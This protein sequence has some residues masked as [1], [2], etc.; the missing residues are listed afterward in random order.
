MKRKILII[1]FLVLI[2]I[3]FVG[4]TANA[5]SGDDD[6]QEINKTVDNILD[7]IDFEDFEKYLSEIPS[8]LFPDNGNIKD[9][10]KLLMSGEGIGDFSSVFSY[11][12]NLLGV[13]VKDKL[14]IF[15]SLII[16]L[17]AGGIVDAMKP[18]GNS[19]V[20]EIVHF[21]IYSSAICIV[22]AIV[23]SLVLSAKQTIDKTSGLIEGVMPIVLALMA[24][25]GQQTSVALYNPASVFTTGLTTVF[26]E[27]VIF[28]IIVS[29]LVVNVVSNIN[30]SLK[31]T[32]L[33]G[34]LAGFIK[35]TFGL[36]AVI[37]SVF[38]TARGIVSGA[39]DGISVKA[40]KYAVNS[41]V[42][43]VGGILKDGVDIII[44]SAILIKNA[45]GIYS[46]IA[47]AGIVIVPIIELIAVSF[48]LKLISAVAEPIGDARAISFIDKV[49]STVNYL[50]ASIL[51]VAFMGIVMMILIL[52]SSQAI[53]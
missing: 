49:S 20:G 23:Y 9:S 6:K 13:T 8:T 25:T 27:N 10:L 22:G 39:F 7:N 48:A 15:I 1:L 50:I 28:P 51:I 53:L 24:A 32:N 43:I 34:F 14:P 2:N 35:W 38:I 11:V 45:V 44:A 21:A 41:S 52:I 47:I 16:L 46:L 18:V 29:M 19:G 3:A 40:V 42:P 30:S 5:E 4:I 31:L 37:F 33:Y 12:L 17:V 26:I 36:L